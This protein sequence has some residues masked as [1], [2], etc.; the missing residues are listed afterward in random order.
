MSA[1]EAIEA[2]LVGRLTPARLRDEL[3]LLLDEPRADESF[4]PARGL[5]RRP[6]VAQASR[7]M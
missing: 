7:P 5:R 2:G 3:L 1:R 4:A 6:A